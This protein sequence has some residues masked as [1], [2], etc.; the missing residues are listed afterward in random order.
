MLDHFTRRV[1][2]GPVRVLSTSAN[3][4]PA[5]GTYHRRADGSFEPHGIQVIESKD[6]LIA[7]IVTFLDAR[8]FPAFGLPTSLPG[9]VAK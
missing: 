8:L 5:I 7:R 4:Y 2:S 1:F 9:P 3:G 6:G